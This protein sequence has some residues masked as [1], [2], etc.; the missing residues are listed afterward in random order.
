MFFSAMSKL[1]SPLLLAIVGVWGLTDFVNA[2]SLS[3]GLCFCL[4]TI[5]LIV[6]SMA[7]MAYASIQ[8]DIMPL[9]LVV[10]YTK[11]NEIDSPLCFQ[12]LD[13]LVRKTRE[14]D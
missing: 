3:L 6:F 9:V 8:T 2:V 12:V 1:V 7:R 10:A 14:T 13:G 4:I 5:K 11:L